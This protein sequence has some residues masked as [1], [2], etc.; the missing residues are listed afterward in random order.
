MHL[1]DSKIQQLND[2]MT[3][4]LSDCDSLE[5]RNISMPIELDILLM[6]LKWLQE[7]FVLLSLEHI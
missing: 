5:I 6:M 7:L 3:Q 1:S 4:Q 2:S